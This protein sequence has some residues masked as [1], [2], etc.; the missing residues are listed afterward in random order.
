MMEGEEESVR[1]IEEVM[2]GE[3]RN[4]SFMGE[5]SKISIEGIEIMGEKRGGRTG[6]L[7]LCLI[8]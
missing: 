4:I 6:G 3:D 1:G 2:D 7:K 5:E 8:W